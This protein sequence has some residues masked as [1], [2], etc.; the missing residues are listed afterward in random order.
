MMRYS[1]EGLWVQPL[2]NQRYRIGLSPKGQDDLGE[3]AFC[4][5]LVVDELVQHD[6]FLGVEAAKAV[7]EL[8]APLNGKVVHWHEAVL[9]CP[10]LLNDPDPEKNWVVCITANDE[11]YAQLQPEDSPFFSAGK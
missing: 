9:D 3:I 11:E 6:S 7:T 8:P 2:G 4:E 10:A 5:F 1:K